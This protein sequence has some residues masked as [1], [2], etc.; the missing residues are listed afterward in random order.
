MTDRVL[1]IDRFGNLEV[2]NADIACGRLPCTASASQ[3]ETLP[4]PFRPRPP[5]WT[6][7]VH[8]YS[9]QNEGRKK[10]REAQESPCRLRISLCLWYRWVA[11]AQ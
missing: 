10:T 6:I 5:Q 11:R 3:S 9:C 1:V 4:A 7:S 2:V 8:L